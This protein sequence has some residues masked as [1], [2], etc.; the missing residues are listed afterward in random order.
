[1]PKDQGS[2]EVEQG[3]ICDYQATRILAVSFIEVVDALVLNER[4]NRRFDTAY[5]SCSAGL[6]IIYCDEN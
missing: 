6:H 3:K 5:C 2:T 1:M 4:L